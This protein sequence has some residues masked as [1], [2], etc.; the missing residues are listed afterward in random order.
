MGRR[1]EIRLL[2]G[3]PEHLQATILTDAKAMT[4]KPSATL[5]TAVGNE[6]LSWLRERAVG[7]DHI[8]FAFYKWPPNGPAHYGILWAYN[9][10][11][12]QTLRVP[13]S[14]TAG[15][16]ET[17]ASWDEAEIE[18]HLFSLKQFGQPTQ[19]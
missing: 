8:S 7:K 19:V 2:E 4:V 17:I 13:F 10:R 9:P 11:T 15:E 6:A 12:D 1:I 14:E 18:L 5:Q 16:R 3:L